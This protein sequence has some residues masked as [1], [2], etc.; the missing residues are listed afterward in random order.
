MNSQVDQD[1]IQKISAR[2]AA[3]LFGVLVGGAAGFLLA[4]SIN[5][6]SG[7]L[8]LCLVGEAEY[9]DFKPERK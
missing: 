7:L 5:N 6:F 2:W 4:L 9:L 8:E 3:G 1:N